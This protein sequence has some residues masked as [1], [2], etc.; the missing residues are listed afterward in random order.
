MTK[1][2]IF[3]M[4]P[5]LRLQSLTRSHRSNWFNDQYYNILSVKLKVVDNEY[6]MHAI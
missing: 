6:V 1:V 5:K 4:L 3:P 2:D